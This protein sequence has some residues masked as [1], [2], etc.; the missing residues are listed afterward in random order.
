MINS[1]LANPL[2]ADT[3]L[4]DI[5]RLTSASDFRSI[6]SVK[7]EIWTVSFLYFFKR[8]KR[9]RNDKGDLIPKASFEII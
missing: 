3:Q 4:H 8:E 9:E 1:R 7:H 5:Y 2:S 6:F